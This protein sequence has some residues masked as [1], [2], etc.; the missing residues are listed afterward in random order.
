VCETEYR[1]TAI[2]RSKR[3]S[4]RFSVYINRKFAASLTADE[5]AG[6]RLAS[7]KKLTPSEFDSFASQF[8]DRRLRESAYRLLSYRSRSEKEIFD[9]LRQK[10][11][12]RKKIEDLIA[13]FR[14]KGLLS[15]RR[16]AE[17]WVDSRMRFK[18]RGRGLLVM[19]LLSKGVDKGLA[20]R[21]VEEKLDG[22]D[23][24]E[25]AFQLLENRRERFI[26]EN[27]IDTKRKI[28][29]YLRYRG[30]AMDDI[31]RAA[32]RFLRQLEEETTN[33]ND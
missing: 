3:V 25:T 21:V 11:F 18:P 16:F 27:S 13:E 7:G 12:P 22:T 30:Y 17:D 33:M 6:Y 10:G 31:L 26:R 29:D 32:D 4:D 24:A 23:E 15:D 19:E 28:Y 9:K 8:E 5:L 2:R 20:E 1:V 14:E